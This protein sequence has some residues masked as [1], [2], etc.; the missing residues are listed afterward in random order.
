MYRESGSM[1][2]RMATRTIHGLTASHFILDSTA[3]VSLA[4]IISQVCNDRDAT[5]KSAVKA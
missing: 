3:N 1:V 5:R 2:E 4:N